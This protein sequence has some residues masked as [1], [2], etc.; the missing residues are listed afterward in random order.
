MRNS[1]C[2]F[3]FF[4]SLC[5]AKTQA[6]RTYAANSVLQNGNFLK[7]G[8]TKAGIYKID[9]AFLNN[10][11]FSGSSISSAAIR[12]YG[13]GGQ[14]LDEKNNGIYHDDLLENA[15]DVVDGGDGL[16]NNNDYF[17]FFAQGPDKWLND[18]LNKKFNHQKNI[19]SDT[20]YYFITI[21]GAGKRINTNANSANANQFVTTYNDRYFYEND[22]VNFLNSGKEWYGE[23]FSNL[24]SNNLSRNFT[25][26]LNGL[27][28]SEPINLSTN[29]A[30][31]SVLTQSSRD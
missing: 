4:C 10:N 22:I 21:G 8:I 13:N 26:D 20:V 1:I 16:F 31:R 18:S 2:F 28:P 5:I 14:M 12:L 27:I 11:G 30:S 19:Y 17:L 6:Q 29:F 9:V 24:S 7:I 3:L 25:I 15:I 23:E